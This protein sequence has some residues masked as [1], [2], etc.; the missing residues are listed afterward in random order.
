MPTTRTRRL[1]ATGATAVG[2]LAG[3]AGIANAA[4]STTDQS[5][6]PSASSAA[7]DNETNDPAPDYTSSVTAPDNENEGDLQALATIGPDEATAAATAATGGTAGETEL[8]NENGN[9]VYGVEVSLPDGS[10]L[11]V[12]VDAGNGTV[13]AQQVDEADGGESD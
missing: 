12:K 10:T 9:V 5:P 1:I 7:A 2:L 6:S 8:E 4:T 3:A 13:L 11:D